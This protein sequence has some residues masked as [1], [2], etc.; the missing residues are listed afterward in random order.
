MGRQAPA[1]CRPLWFSTMRSEATG[2]PRLADRRCA[3]CAS[4]SMPLF[5]TKQKGMPASCTWN[6]GGCS[7][8]SAGLCDLV[9]ACFSAAVTA[10][11]SVLA[12]ATYQQL[13]AK[14]LSLLVDK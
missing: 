2:K 8:S 3:L 7:A 11:Q 1:S 6:G 4:L 10:K 5:V 12:S 9:A 14:L 13:A